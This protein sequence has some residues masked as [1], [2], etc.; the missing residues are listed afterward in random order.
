MSVRPSR[1]RRNLPFDID[2]G[3]LYAMGEALGATA[4]QMRLA[5]S[6]ALNRTVQTATKEAVMLM[7]E[8]VGIKSSKTLK[9]RSLSISHQREVQK[10]LGGMKLWFGL[11]AV[12][13][14]ELAGF[15]PGKIRERHTLRDPVTG[16][17]ISDES[18]ENNTVRFRPRGEALK[19][20]SKEA[21]F[22]NAYVNENRKGKKTIFVRGVNRGVREA[23]MDIY[24]PMLD[25][26][27]DD[28]FGSV[29]E[30]FLKHYE[31]DLRGRVRAG[32]HVNKRTGRRI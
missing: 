31:T 22:E 12:R 16:Q 3:D 20:M 17:Y 30:I 28:I 24:E 9:A 29:P 13:I 14:S 4:D 19:K 2:I 7:R 1:A 23:E 10:E 15:I 5:Y 11:N 27:E 32:V 6:R 18:T 21:T 26:I 8:Q 25:K